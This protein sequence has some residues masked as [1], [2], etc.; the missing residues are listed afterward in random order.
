MSFIVEIPQSES[1][2][3]KSGWQLF[4]L[5][6]T[7]KLIP[8]L[9]WRNPAYRHKFM[10]RSLATPFS[11]LRFLNDLAQQ[12]Q[13][14]QIL[15][16]QPGL[17][18][19]LHRP[20]LSITMPRTQAID[21]LRWHYQ[22]FTRVL[23]VRVF[24]RYLTPNGVTLAVL[25]GKDEQ[26]YTVRLRADAMLD[27]EGEATLLFCDSQETMLAELTFTLCRVG[28][29]NTLYIGGL[30]GAKAQV[31]HARIQTATKACHGLFPK[32]LLVEAAMTLGQQL[33]AEQIR[34]VSNETHIYRSLRY[35]RKKHEHLHA[36]Y[37]SF[38]ASLGASV[39]G[40]GDYL[41]PRDMPRK[42]ME[43][44]ASKKRAEYRRRYALLDSLHHQTRETCQR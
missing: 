31:P 42:P 40:H 34:A 1:T 43:E 21:A 24:N 11:T 35:R 13:L 33:G 12:P 3:L 28:G 30:Q 7:G 44:I 27:K 9:A 4:Q 14:M 18:C 25:S 8:G 23:P 16:A 26:R 17:P 29:K 32:R 19:R 10:L 20:W 36:D 39:D 5:L 22:Q 2:Q 37:N 38:W 6:R 41:L 15:N